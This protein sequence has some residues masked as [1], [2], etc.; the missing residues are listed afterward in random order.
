MYGTVYVTSEPLDVILDPNNPKSV[1]ELEHEGGHGLQEALTS[2]TSLFL[3]QLADNSV[4]MAWAW[5][6]GNTR[7]FFSGCNMVE[8]MAGYKSGGYTNCL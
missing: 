3:I 2:T 1:M 5:T 8:K 7:A 4:E 6:H